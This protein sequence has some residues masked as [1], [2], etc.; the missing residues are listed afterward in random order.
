MVKPERCAVA[1]VIE[2]ELGQPLIIQRPE[3]DPELGGLWGLPALAHDCAQDQREIA[4]LVG[5]KKLGV[6][7]EIRQKIGEQTMDRGNYV[8]RL[9]DF[10]AKIVDGTPSVPQSDETLVQYTSFQ[11]ASDPR[12]LCISAL[13]GSVC[14]RIYLDSLHINWRGESDHE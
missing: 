2:N 3:S 10:S 11:Y 4:K 14:S 9:A 13:K 6:E 7:L 12:I 1:V 5:P 8:L